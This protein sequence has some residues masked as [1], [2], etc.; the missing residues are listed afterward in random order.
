MSNEQKLQAKSVLKDA[1]CCVNKKYHI[2][3]ISFF[4][5]RQIRQLVSLGSLQHLKTCFV[6]DLY[7]LLC[8][9]KGFKRLS[10]PCDLVSAFVHRKLIPKGA[11][12]NSRWQHYLYRAA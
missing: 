7:D 11:A 8:V 12:R 4:G 1:Y 5:L 2:P 10:R 3:G 6:P 9:V